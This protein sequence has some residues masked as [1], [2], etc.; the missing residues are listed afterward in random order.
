ML[1]DV[2]RVQDIVATKTGERKTDA[3]A[4]K[5]PRYIIQSEQSKA[6][7]DNKIVRAK[8]AKCG[9]IADFPFSTEKRERR[10]R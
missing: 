1:A 5:N 3:I 10:T 6:H 2:N 9:K 8:E 4:G 7:S